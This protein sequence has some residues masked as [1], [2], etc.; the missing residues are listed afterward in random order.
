MKAQTLTPAEIFGN[1][2]RYVVPLFQ[3]PYVWTREDQWE[4]LWLDVCALADRLLES[5]SAPYMP[6]GLPPHFLG[7]VVVDQPLTAT[8]FIAVR[9]VIDGQQR[10]TTLQ[11][12]LHAA[13]SVVEQHGAAMDAQALRVLVANPPGIVHEEQDQFKVWPTDRDQEAFRAALGARPVPAELTGQRLVQAHDFFAQSVTGWAE[14]LGDPDKCVRRLNALTHALR[15]HLKLVVIDLEPGDNAQVIFETLNHRG[16]PLLAADLVKNLLFQLASAQGA[17][18]GGLYR[19]S[20][21]VFDSDYWRQPVAQGRR[22]R[23]RVDIFLNYWLVTRTLRE[24]PAD[25]VFT[26]FRDYVR[27]LG[28]PV[29]E[30]M[31]DLHADGE[32]YAG[33]ESLPWSSIPGTFYYRVVRMLDS[34]AVGPLLLWLLRRRDEPIPTVQ[35]HRA[36]G[37]VESWLV[38][39]T[40]CRMTLKDL[41]RV[42]VELL[43]EL[44]E[45]PIEQAGQVIEEFLARQ[46]SDSRLWPTD[47]QLTDALGADTIYT[48]LSR[49]R[50]RMVLEAIEDDLRGPMSEHEHCPR[51]VLTIEHVMPRGWREHW[52]ADLADDLP[53]ALRRDRIVHTLGNLTLVNGKL[54]P[55][56]SNRSWTS[57]NTAPPTAAHQGKRD[58]LL[59]H[60]VLKLNARLA[61][62]HPDAW[63]EQDINERTLALAQRVCALWPRPDSPAPTKPSAPI[64]AV[65]SAPAPDGITVP[66]PD[67][68]PVEHTGKHRA[69]WAWLCEQ[70]GDEF[71]VTFAQ[72][73]QVLDAPLPDSCRERPWSCGVAEPVS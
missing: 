9:T 60:S 47:E 6:G 46:G 41:N 14:P 33:L 8:G 61:T 50:L 32:V 64:A 10:L 53:G 16:A 35:V 67:A 17:D 26:E 52:G 38:R 19:S 29:R 21:R 11:L 2:V 24:V 70:E 40:L 73:E 72:I 20:W 45:H 58:L 65:T 4:P 1:Q 22:Y 23:P 71:I 27:V 15:E 63:T 59:A 49:G 7:A 28:L 30:V 62:A 31:A 25:R 43:R 42:V 18:L 56:L 68:A 39:R 13:A 36:L 66:R 48:H 37:A 51:G 55:A 44:S 69:L 57:A 12:L 54:N 5:T 34:A 3:R